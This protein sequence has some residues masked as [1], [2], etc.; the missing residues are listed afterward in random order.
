M[1]PCDGVDRRLLFAYRANGK[2][3]KM[4]YEIEH[5]LEEKEPGNQPEQR[6][7]GEESRSPSGAAEPQP[8]AGI[9]FRNM[10]E[11]KMLTPEQER[12]LGEEISR[13][14]RLLVFGLTGLIRLL[15][16]IPPSKIAPIPPIK[17]LALWVED[18]DPRKIRQVL[19]LL[20]EIPKRSTRAVRRNL[21][22][23]LGRIEAVQEKLV[24]ANLRLVASVAR[25]YIGNGLLLLDLVQEGNIGLMRAAEKFNPDKGCRFS[26][27]A[28]W[29]IHQRIRRAIIEQ[30]ET[31][32][33]PVHR[34]L[35]QRKAHRIKEDLTRELGRKPL[36]EEVARRGRIPHRRLET[37][38]DFVQDVVA[39]QQP[40]G[41][42]DGELQDVIADVSLPPPDEGVRRRE[43]RKEVSRLLAMLPEKDERMVRMHYGIGFE[44]EFTLEEIGEVFGLTRERVRQ[45]EVRAFQKLR[46]MSPGKMEAFLPS[47]SHGR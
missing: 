17:S 40:I 22:E 41:G 25:R 10:R 2:G 47:Y 46:R 44:R 33:V 27:Y 23:G 42:E 35:L 6:E 7:R 32:R 28:T 37:V 36:T 39:L 26:T 21:R 43:F 3:N 11:R 9:Y 29:W 14:R 30:G 31:I 13:G 12:M 34:V 19:N 18:P 1:N 45:I 8:L 38:G 5:P 15:R 24:L 16:K 20:E 4:L